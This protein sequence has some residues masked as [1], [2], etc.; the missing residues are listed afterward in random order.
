MMTIIKILGALAA[1]AVVIT[2]AVI[3]YVVVGLALGAK[4]RSSLKNS[5]TACSSPCGS[6]PRRPASGYTK[7]I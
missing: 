5:S 3:L 7:I 2:G 6:S 1:G 4:G